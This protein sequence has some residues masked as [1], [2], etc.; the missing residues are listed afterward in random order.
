MHKIKQLLAPLEVGYVVDT[1]AKFRVLG[2]AEPVFVN[3]SGD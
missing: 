2:Q 1:A 3:V